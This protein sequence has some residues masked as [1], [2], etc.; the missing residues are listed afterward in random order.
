MS[1]ETASTK[2]VSPSPASEAT[3]FTLLPAIDLRHGAVV[4]LRQG[5]DGRR[6][7]YFD[8]PI[9]VLERFAAA[10]ARWV[11]AVDLDAAFGEP[12]QRELVQRMAVAGESLGVS[13][14]LGGGL[15]D[16]AAVRWALD[17]GC[18][19]AVVGSLLGRDFEAFAAIVEAHP[20]QVVPGL[21]FRNARLAVSGWTETVD[22]GPA[23]LAQRLRGLPCPAALVTDV[24]RDG[25]LGGP[26]LD[27]AREVGGGSGIP[28]LVS[29]GVR[30]LEDLLA[31]RR[32]PGVGGAVV[33][34]AIYTAQLD[35]ASALSRLAEERLSAGGVAEELS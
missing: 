35:L 3:D 9:P 18:R 17:V 33:G 8:D 15:R 29:G 19:R 25:E 26:G 20:G 6:T 1:S 23:E 30:H 4:R 16:A 32:T 5:D 28:A 34:Q 11:H 31:A 14:E 2:S 22:V 13:L 27:L 24:A 12:P 21:D 10:G 7:R